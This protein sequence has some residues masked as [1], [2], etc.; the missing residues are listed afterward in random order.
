MADQTVTLRRSRDELGSRFLGA[1]LAADGTLSITGQDLGRGVE[2][3]F[4]DGNTEY[5]WAWTLNP[6]S[7]VA[8]AKSLDCDNV[9]DGLVAKFSGE[10]AAN[11]KSHLDDNGIDYQAWTRIGD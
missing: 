8:L 3:I 10:A 9:L 6:A 1:T 7:V 11:L 4:G 2:H 5:E